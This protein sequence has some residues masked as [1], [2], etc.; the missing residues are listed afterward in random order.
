MK[1]LSNFN[2]RIKILLLLD[3]AKA[4]LFKNVQKH[5]SRR[6]EISKTKVGTFFC[7]TLYV[8]IPIRELALLVESTKL[9]PMWNK[10]I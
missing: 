4:G 7:N 6:F 2:P 10:A 1:S 9:N 5:F 8:F 3:S